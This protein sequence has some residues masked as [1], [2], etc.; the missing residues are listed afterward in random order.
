M[1]KAPPPSTAGKQKAFATK[2]RK[3]QERRPFDY[4]QDRQEC[5]CHKGAGTKP[6][7]SLPVE[8]PARPILIEDG[9]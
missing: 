2:A 1:Q 9:F 3:T 7:T 4:A 6:G 8:C 5:L